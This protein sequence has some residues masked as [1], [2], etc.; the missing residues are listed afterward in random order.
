MKHL[1]GTVAGRAD[2]LVVH[3]IETGN[4]LSKMMIH[5]MGAVA[6]GVVLGATVPLIVN[7][8]TDPI[9]ARR[10]SIGLAHSHAAW[11]AGNLS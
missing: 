7:S 1:A 9:D 5:L 8:R 3:D 11:Q 4:A 10:A 2:I 6:G